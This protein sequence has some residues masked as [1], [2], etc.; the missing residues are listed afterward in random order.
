MVFTEIKERNKK[1]YYYRVLSVRNSRK[2]AKKR[3]YLGVD[4][5]KKDLQK[6]EAEADKILGIENKKETEALK[7]IKTQI[8]KILKQYKIKKASI[9]GSYARGDFKK[10]SDIDL[11]IQPTPGMGLEFVGLALELEDK[12]GKKIDLLTYKSIHPLIKKSVMEDEIRI[13]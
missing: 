8:L 7:K 5:S 6:K 11:I 10:K 1:K 4:L 13:I 2:V 12:L 3:K 9:F